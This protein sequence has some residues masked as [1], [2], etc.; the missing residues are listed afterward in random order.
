MNIPAF[1]SY[2][3]IYETANA[4]LIH[5]YAVIYEMANARLIFPYAVIYEMANA[6]LIL[7]DIRLSAGR[8]QVSRLYAECLTDTNTAFEQME[9]E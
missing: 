4:R 2:A 8:D 9:G 3:V 7:P 1:F 6:R 5:P